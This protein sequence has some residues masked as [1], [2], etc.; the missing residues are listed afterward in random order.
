MRPVLFMYYCS[1]PLWLALILCDPALLARTLARVIA[2]RPHF[3]LCQLYRF[4]RT[5]LLRS[6]A[7]CYLPWHSTNVSVGVSCFFLNPASGLVLFML[8]S[9]V[10]PHM[11]AT[12][13]SVCQFSASTSRVLLLPH[14]AVAA[15]T[16]PWKSAE[17][18][19][20]TQTIT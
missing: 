4:I 14:H 20:I 18:D 10:H 6:R 8:T 16:W 19:D 17:E 5:R 13:C 11:I 3:G 1:C 12:E 2:R 9:V 7:I 15:K